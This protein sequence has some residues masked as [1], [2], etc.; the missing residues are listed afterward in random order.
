MKC[1]CGQKLEEISTNIYLAT[2]GIVLVT[3]SPDW[4]FREDFME[5]ILSVNLKNRGDLGR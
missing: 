1:E 2:K 3:P 5:E 4:G